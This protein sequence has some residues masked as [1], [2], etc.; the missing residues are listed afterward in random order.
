MTAPNTRRTSVGFR[1]CQVLLITSSGYPAASGT[2][3]YEGVQVTRAKA[4][5]LNDPAPQQITSIGDDNI[6]QVDYLPPNEA[7]TGEVR[8]GI[9]DDVL[10]DVVTD[11]A[12]I[13]IGEAKLFGFGTN[14][15]G[16]ENQVAVLAFRQ[17]L[18]S[19]P[20]DTAEGSRCWDFRLFPKAYLIP[21]ESGMDGGATPEERVYALRPQF[22]GSYPWGKAFAS[23]TE[24]FTRA[25]GLRGISQ[26]KPK[27]VAF[28]SNGSD[29]AFAFPTA[30]P[31]A[32]AGKIITWVDGVEQTTGLTEATTGV[33]FSA[34]PTSGAYIVSFYEYD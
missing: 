26:Y 34:A 18:D 17:S 33:T 11:D 25:Q 9:T 10:D 12:S 5:S 31:A 8:T 3:A 29:V 27:I 24:G 14:N 23:G 32:D 1:H 20:G 21:Q 4:L 28:L 22:V 7:I 2:E 6:F 19:T 15:R 13:T 30:Y 16:A